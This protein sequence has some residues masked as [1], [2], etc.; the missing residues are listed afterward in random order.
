MFDLNGFKNYNDSFGHLAGDALL[1][2]LGSALA[3]AVARVRRPRLPAGRRRVLR[4]R[5]APTRQHAIE[6]AACRALSEHG[7]GFAISTAFGSVVIPQDTGDATEAMR[8]A[9]QAMYAQKHSGRA[10]AGR[11]SSDVLMRALAE[12]H[13]DLGDHH[14][15]VAELVA[16]GRQP[17]GHRRRRARA[18]A[19]TPHRCTTSAR[20]RSPTRS[21]PSP[22]P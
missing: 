11:Q 1:L 8:K 2:R 13:P 22:G 6:Q 3:E 14:D 20:S 5:R 16:G 12:R 18:A 17:A 7:E 19:R 4:H 9:D 21:S 10:T 15:G